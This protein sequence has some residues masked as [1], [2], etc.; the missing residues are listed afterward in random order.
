MS[1]TKILIIAGTMDVGGIENQ[2]MRLR[3][4]AEN[5][6]AFRQRRVGISFANAKHSI[7]S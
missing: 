5:A 4:W 3:H 2:L 6:S 1:Q 7:K